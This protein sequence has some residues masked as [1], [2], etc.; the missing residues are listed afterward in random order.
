[1]EGRDQGRPAQAEAVEFREVSSLTTNRI[2]EDD[3]TWANM[4]HRN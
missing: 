3:K 4:L 2:Q 1:M